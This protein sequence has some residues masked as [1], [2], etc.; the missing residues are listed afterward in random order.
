MPRGVAVSFIPNR[1]VLHAGHD[2]A[3]PLACGRLCDGGRSVVT[4]VVVG[5]DMAVWLRRAVVV[6]VV[7]SAMVSQSLLQ[8]LLSA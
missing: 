6:S 4:A 3:C 1:E 7:V 2:P 5:V 8:C